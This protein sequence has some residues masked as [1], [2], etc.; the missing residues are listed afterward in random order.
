MKALKALTVSVPFSGVEF[1]GAFHFQLF[2]SPT[3]PDLELIFFPL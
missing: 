2:F 3:A 1:C